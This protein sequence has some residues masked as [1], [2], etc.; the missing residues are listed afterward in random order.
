M[1]LPYQRTTLDRIETN[2]LNGVM[3]SK[4][5]VYY[6]VKAIRAAED[7]R[8]YYAIDGRLTSETFKNAMKPLLKAEPVLEDSK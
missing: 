2:I 1:N 3:P 6:L 4:D 7:A 5:E 8:E